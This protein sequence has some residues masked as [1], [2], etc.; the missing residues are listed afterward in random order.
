MGLFVNDV[1]YSQTFKALDV[2]TKANSSTNK[3]RF[4]SFTA[5]EI[6][7]IVLHCNG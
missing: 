7:T 2:K 5:S 3:I 6:G 4:C 1:T